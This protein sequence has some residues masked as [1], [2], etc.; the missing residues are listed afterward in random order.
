MLK[1]LFQS[2]DKPD[3]NGVC[4]QFYICPLIPFQADAPKQLCLTLR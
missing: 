4:L 1:L 2:V 3:Y